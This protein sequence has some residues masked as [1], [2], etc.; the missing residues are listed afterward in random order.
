MTGMERELHIA[1]TF[2]PDDQGRYLRLP[3]DVPENTDRVEVAYAYERFV[4]E[5]LP[6]GRRKREAA[7]VDLGL[8]DESGRLRGWSGSE[9]SSVAV[10][11][12]S[13]TPGYAAGP[14]R[15]GR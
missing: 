2:R 11:A 9:R 12:S 4:T 10:S 14:V 3:F 13:A 5:D 6:D 8:Y 15:A 7:I 1:R